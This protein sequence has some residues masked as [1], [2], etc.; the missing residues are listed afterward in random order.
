MKQREQ[1]ELSE[2]ERLLTHQ[3]IYYPSIWP[4]AYICSPL[5]AKSEEEAVKNMYMARAY[6]YYVYKEMEQLARA[7]HAYLPMLLCDFLPEERALALQFGLRLLEKCDRLMVCGDRISTGMKGEILH[8]ISI[9]MRIL[10][11]SN[12]MYKKVCEYVKQENGDMER[13]ELVE[14][15]PFMAGKDQIQIREKLI[16]ENEYTGLLDARNRLCHFCQSKECEEC[17]VTKLADDAHSEAEKAG[18]ISDT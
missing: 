13:V 10:T 6:M 11:F 18:I 12:P 16:S 3:F 9:N 7:P 14:D 1:I 15:H 4:K 2:I 17:Q 8:A 5:G